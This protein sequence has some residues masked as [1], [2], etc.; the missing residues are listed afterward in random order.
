MKIEQLLIREPFGS[1]LE[2][3]LTRFFSTYFETPF[4][5][6]WKKLNFL[7]LIG[8]S[9]SPGKEWF[10]CNP[11]LN[12]IY[13]AKA[14][15]F[16]FSFLRENYMHTPFPSR[17]LMQKI[18]V[19]LAA[20]K[21]TARFFATYLLEIS[22]PI[23]DSS[24]LVILGGN[25]RIRIVDLLEKRSW[26]VLKTGF[27]T[28]YIRAE[29]K[30][31][32][33]EGTWPF[34][35][36]KIVAEDYSWF[37]SEHI[38]AVSLNRLP[39]T[40]NNLKFLAEAFTFLCGWLEQSASVCGA[41]SYLD[42]LICEVEAACS[43]P[44]FSDSDRELVSHTL[45]SA[46]QILHRLSNKTGGPLIYLAEGHGDFQSGNILI[47]DNSAVW[48]VD[49]EHARKRQIAYDYLVFFL[50]SRFPLGLSERIHT[51]LKSGDLILDGLPVVHDRVNEILLDDDHRRIM[52]LLFVIEDLLWNVREN[53]NHLFEVP[54]GAWLQYKREIIPA[55]KHI[56]EASSA[57][58]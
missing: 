12:I 16:V 4:S 39:G 28:A 45:S 36:L 27:D 49:W 2:K 55:I 42:D 10:Y 58:I 30:A 43:G 47:D 32:R 13:S 29:V 33:R 48:I 52:L 51:L 7:Q 34:P 14:G 15:D 1:I 44:L 23:P 21:Y 19:T 3:T 26:D 25:N 57:Q 40:K 24:N 20:N 38:Q 17:R 37:E 9:P 50:Q 8:K 22:P 31:R 46:Q 53:A 6:T 5:V 56:A 41:F 54:S 11:Y 35:Q 18:Y